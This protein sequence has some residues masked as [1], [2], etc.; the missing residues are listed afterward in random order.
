MVEQD[1]DWPRGGRHLAKPQ[2]GPPGPDDGF[3]RQHAPREG[4]SSV[5]VALAVAQ[6]S[7]TGPADEELQR[8]QVPAPM[9]RCCGTT[10]PKRPERE[11]QRTTHEHARSQL[12]TRGGPARPR[13]LL[14]IGLERDTPP[15]CPGAR[16]YANKQN[17]LLETKDTQALERKRVEGNLGWTC[18]QNK[19]H[20]FVGGSAAPCDS[21]AQRMPGPQPEPPPENAIRL[22]H[23]LAQRPSA[24]GAVPISHEISGL[25]QAPPAETVLLERWNA[26]H[27]L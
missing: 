12:K 7:V 14:R 19:Q 11:A 2:G 15:S 6:C 20:A 18:K 26:T 8:S 4:C 17:E 3:G 27:E 25:R 21:R 22:C 16:Q 1:L 10:T 5:L 24:L 23:R 9:E 13:K